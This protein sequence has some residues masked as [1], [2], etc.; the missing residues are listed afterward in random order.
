MK[1]PIYANCV[2]SVF[3]DAMFVSD[4]MQE[5]NGTSTHYPTISYKAE[6]E[7]LLLVINDLVGLKEKPNGFQRDIRIYFNL[8]QAERLSKRIKRHY[9]RVETVKKA[10]KLPSWS[11]GNNEDAKAITGFDLG[12]GA[13]N[14]IIGEHVIS[15][16]NKDHWLKVVAYYSGSNSKEADQYEVILHIDTENITAGAGGEADR[17]ESGS[18]GM[19]AIPPCWEG[20][21]G[22][23][24]PAT[25][26]IE[27]KKWRFGKLATAIDECIAAINIEKR[28]NEQNV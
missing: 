14:F 22:N 3:E 6:D 10:D 13:L 19:I 7:R 4:K 8:K 5:R 12:S 20:T 15:D 23:V 11:S 2:W 18:S 28:E 26:V 9:R 24:E 17:S 25:I 16:S 1:K 21:K 27:I